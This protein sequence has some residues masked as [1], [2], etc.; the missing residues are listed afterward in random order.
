MLSPKSLTIATAF[1]FFAT[2][3]GVSN[4]QEVQHK[5]ADDA[6]FAGLINDR[7]QGSEYTY[8]Q[9]VSSPISSM[10]NRRAARYQ[11]EKRSWFDASGWAEA[12]YV[13]NSTKPA[14]KRNGP[15]GFNDEHGRIQLN[16]VYLKLVA[17]QKEDDNESWSWDARIDLLFGT[18]HDYTVAS[19]LEVRKDGSQRWNKT[20]N[21]ITDNY[22]GTPGAPR[23]FYGLSLPQLYADLHTPWL[24]GMDIR[25]G[26]FYSQLGYESMMAVENFFYTHTMSRIH[27]MPMTHTGAVAS[28]QLFDMMDV[29]L[30]FT[31]GWDNWEDDDFGDLSITGGVAFNMEE[32]SFAINFHTGDDHPTVD[33]ALN[34]IV[35]NVTVVTVQYTRNLSEQTKYAIVGNVGHGALMA[36]DTNTGSTTG[37][38]WY[39]IANYLTYDFGP[40]LSTGVRVE[41][42]RDQDNAR[43]LPGAFSQQVDGGNY[44]NVTLGA[45]YRHNDRWTFRPEARWD[46]SDTRSTDLS[47][48]GAFGD[49]TQN[50]TF[51]LSFD[52]I[53]TY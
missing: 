37:A 25:M 28:T 43:I 3:A 5:D 32:S 29:S 23:P 10:I 7:V 20:P 38:R 14:S 26:H 40:K 1:A 16:Q 53:F 12:G 49:F 6:Y 4:A 27:G 39:G 15:I 34:P 2:I 31:R 9:E 22:R 47:V 46:W 48:P 18:D 30:G 21:P 17:S 52:A 50:D 19:G 8:T 36:G 51:T 35:G 41:W 24:F 44:V 13:W 45:N 11:E 33:N 42:F